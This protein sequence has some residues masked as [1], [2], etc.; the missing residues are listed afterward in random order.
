MDLGVQIEPQFGFKFE[1]VLEIA[2]EAERA[3]FTRLWVSDHL[4]LDANAVNT[5]CLEAWTLLAALAVRTE[6][7]RLGPMVTA[8]SYRNPALLAKIAA[9][10]D[11]MS[12]GRLDFGLGA[13][14]KDIEYR[15][16]NYEFPDAP[17]RVTQMI[18]TLEICTRMWKDERATYQGK[19]YRIENALCAP[20]PVQKPLPI[21]IG[22][23]KP[24][25]MR[26]AAKYGQAFNITVS[27]SAPNDLPDR[28]RDLDEACRAEK[29]DPKTLLRSAFLVACVG[30]TRS[31]AEARLDEIAKRQKTDRK[32]LLASRPGLVFGTPDEAAEKL[33][34]YADKGIGHANIMFQP[35]GSER[36]QIAA[37]APVTSQFR[38]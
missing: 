6:R 4:F 15:A 11:V 32:S 38:S 2:L 35:F 21:W 22:G 33:R 16:Y 9:G 12:K 37:L 1:D 34:S 36:D 18:E 20:K 30:K 27:A 14:W 24:R 28:L 26:A 25:V 13:G 29:R 19:H 17:T 23:S 31:E 10:V 7:I 3:G 8:Q 5:D